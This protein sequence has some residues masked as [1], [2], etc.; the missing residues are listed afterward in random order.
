MKK[1]KRFFS[2]ILLAI[3]IIEII[4]IANSGIVGNAVRS[5]TTQKSAA[6]STDAQKS[7]CIGGDHYC[8]WECNNWVLD[9][10][11][12]VP[13]V[14]YFTEN[15]TIQ[16]FLVSNVVHWDDTE[17]RTY[18]PLI[19]RVNEITV[20]LTNDLDKATAIANWVT[21]SKNYSFPSPANERKSIIEIFNSATGVCMDAA[22]LTTAMFRI[23][24]I[25]SRAILPDMHE[26]TEAYVNG[27]WMGFDAT[28]GDGDS[29]IM[30]QITALSITTQVYEK[31]PYRVVT[32]SPTPTNY[33]LVNITY[34]KNNLIP[35]EMYKEVNMGIEVN[36]SVN[37]SSGPIK[38]A[39][40]EVSNPFST[41]RYY[42]YSFFLNLSNTIKYYYINCGVIF[43][44]NPLHWESSV[45]SIQLIGKYL[46]TIEFTHNNFVKIQAT[47]K[48]VSTIA[49]GWGEIS[50]PKTS[51]YVFKNSDSK[52]NLTY[53]P[54]LFVDKTSIGW[55]LQSDN[56]NCD[57]YSCYYNNSN[58]YSNNFVFVGINGYGIY[59]ELG[60]AN[61]M[62][63]DHYNGLVK[64][65]LPE[66]RYKLNYFIY[67][68]PYNVGY[69][70]F[71]IQNNTSINI[72]LNQIS[73]NVSASYDVYQLLIAALNKSISC[74]TCGGGQI[75]K[76]GSCCTLN[77]CPGLGKQCGTWSNGC[78]GNMDCGGC[79][80]GLACNSN[81]QCVCADNDGDGYGVCM[82]DCNDNNANIRPNAPEV[83]D[84]IDN[85][86]NGKIDGEELS[87]YCGDGIDNDC[88]GLADGADVPTCDCAANKFSCIKGNPTCTGG[89]IK[90]GYW[91]PSGNT[92][93]RICYRYYDKKCWCWKNSCEPESVS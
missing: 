89:T 78:G 19:N 48:N 35:R 74:A 4:L 83:C 42:N 84:G 69:S 8:P 24:G 29:F 43:L 60:N 79:G 45:I 67:E 27:K 16:E 5:V 91:C 80:P 15:R 31:E 46:K 65:N 34:Y 12:G 13:Q 68:Y 54:S 1:K 38:E 82:G 41:I 64:F 76:N 52:Y 57:F 2:L 10:D 36:W 32:F 70:Y 53:N 18:T 55:Y 6:S 37:N 49:L 75:C 21:H 47:V 30:P 17:W 77:T 56:L 62:P 20:G 11:C 63:S 44:S 81:G 59:P 58:N 14:Y 71:Q 85:N 50:I 9:S 33:N 66:G 92:C 61:G 39:Y 3:V 87:E 40:C 51:M 86:C 26:Y 72:S 22:L 90:Q 7:L 88:D 25:P 28:F 23:A 73:Q 93:C